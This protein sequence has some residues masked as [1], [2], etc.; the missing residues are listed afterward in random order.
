[1]KLE[2][3]IDTWEALE[4]AITGGADRIELCAALSEGGLTPPYAFIEKAMSASVPCFVMI[5]PRGADFLYSSAEIEMMHRDIYF[6]K[7][8]C[9]L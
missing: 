4:A 9:F 1:M 2:I 6:A 3:C 5:R 7:K 8:G